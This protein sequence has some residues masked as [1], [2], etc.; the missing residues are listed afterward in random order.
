M[1]DYVSISEVARKAGVGKSTAA[2]VISGTGSVKASTRQKVI[3]AAEELGYQRNALVDSWMSRVRGKRATAK[4][5]CIAWLD[6]GDKHPKHWAP[7]ARLYEGAEQAAARLNI[8]LERISRN[9]GRV[10]LKRL[11]DILFHRNIAGCILFMPGPHY[12]SV[13][14]FDKFPVVVLGDWLHDLGVPL[15][16]AAH[17]ENGEKAFTNLHKLGY[18]RIALV[19]AR[20]SHDFSQK[21]LYSTFLRCC[22]EVEQPP[23][24]HIYESNQVEESVDWII[25]SGSDAVIVSDNTFKERLEKKGKGVPKDIGIAHL[26]A[27]PEEGDFAGIRQAQREMGQLASEVLYSS[28]IAGKVATQQFSVRMKMPGKW[29]GGGTVKASSKSAW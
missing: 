15:I 4:R 25:D 18:K 22:Q 16:S 6:Q 10:S 9:G 23:L 26:N 2:R 13:F 3:E 12:R 17:S 21:S 28:I 20:Y 7:I 1:N 11:N 24:I 14:S 5:L 19:I 27:I 8:R 29:V